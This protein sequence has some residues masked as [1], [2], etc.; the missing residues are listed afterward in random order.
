MPDPL[1]RWPAFASEVR[2][3]LEAGRAAYGD[4]SF[5]REPDAL[6]AELQQ[7]ALDLAGWGFILFQRLERAREALRLGD[8][9]K[10]ELAARQEGGNRGDE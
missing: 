10:A 3:R 2:A 4:K 7:E 1:D 9:G 5:H 8:V 6:L